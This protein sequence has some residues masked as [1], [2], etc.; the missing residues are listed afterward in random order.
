MGSGYST[1]GR[2]YSHGSRKPSSTGGAADTVQRVISG[3]PGVEESYEEFVEDCRI[4][5]LQGKTIS[6][7]RDVI[8][9]ILREDLDIEDSQ[10]I[11]SFTR[12]TMIGPL[13]EDS[14]A[15]VMIVLDADSHRQWIEQENG[16][17][18][19]LQAIRRRIAN[20]PRF[21][22][23]DVTVDQN[24]VR[25]QYHDSTIEVVPAFPY[26]VVPHAEHPGGLF[27]LFGDASDGYAIPDTHGRQSWMGTN[28]RKY[29]QMFEARNRSHNGRVA[30]LT[31]SMKKWAENN[32]VP[33]RSYHMEIMVY[34]YFEE[35]AQAG[36]P[37]PNSFDE[38]AHDF[39]ETM[40]GRVRGTTREPVY[41]EAVD[42]GMSRRDKRDAAQLADQAREKLEKA[43]RLKEAGKTK[44]AKEKLEEV[45]REDFR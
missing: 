18:N 33:V 36:D 5:D 26:S 41:D 13:T 8:E 42:R 16:P 6:Q 29:K 4:T 11:G 39:M 43:K 24:A 37:V 31:R 12:D 28:P 7:R 25:V 10:L 22:D 27:G 2:S 14:D 17:Q 35:K 9:S 3:E 44:E 38:L 20:D 23:T 1:A 32:N 34:N 19:C 30:G 45:Y 15:D 21:S 40:P